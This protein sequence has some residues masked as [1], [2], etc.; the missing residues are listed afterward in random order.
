MITDFHTHAFPD[1]LAPR[2]IATLEA[3]SGDWQAHTDGTVA[4][5][6]V[7][8]DAAGVARSVVCP[9]A[10]RPDQFDGILAWCGAIRSERIVPLGS[11]HPAADDVA[12]QVCQVADAGLVG[13]KLHP[14]YQH[15][16]LDEPRLDPLYAAAAE[17]GL[18]IEFHCG[19][20]IAYRGDDSAEPFRLA[21]VAER[22]PQLTIV[23]THMG[24]WLRWQAVREHLLGRFAN[25]W[26][27]TS[28]S[29]DFLPDAEMVALIRGQG[30]GRVLFG[31]DSPWADQ[32]EQLA[33]LRRLDL[34]DAEQRA[35]LQD[36]AQTLLESN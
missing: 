24:G 33:H 22:H 17:A 13:L 27:E 30:V 8:M 16:K 28:F 26:M 36:N 32:A 9:I 19:D 20:D 2:A 1:S 23:A 6:L 11:V 18:F 4:G 12:G 21:A 5:L 29:M 15:F 14:M 10:T 7:S 25:L 34:T 35:I 31:T 3:G